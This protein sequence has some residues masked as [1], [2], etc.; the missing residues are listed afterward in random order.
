MVDI[1]TPRRTPGRLIAGALLA[2]L[3]G[4]TSQYMLALSPLLF[5]APVLTALTYAYAGAAAA[6]LSCAVQ[7]GV[8]YA[9]FGAALAALEFILLVAPLAFTLWTLRPGGPPL[10]EALRRTLPVWLLCAVLTVGLARYLVGMDL[11]DYLAALVR[12]ELEAL[13]AGMLDSF[14]TLFYGGDA[15]EALNLLTYS[16]GF[17]DP[18]ERARSV[19]SLTEALR[20]TLALSVPGTLLTSAALTGLLATA[21]PLRRLVREGALEALRW[22]PLN[23]W[24]LP[25]S[26]AVAATVFY[27]SSLLLF[28]FA[29]LSQAQSVAMALQMLAALA[30]RV[31][32]VGSLERRLRSMR[33]GARRLLI[34]LLLLLPLTANLSV[35][36]GMLSSLF[37]PTDGAVTRY[38]QKRRARHGGD[39]DTNDDVDGGGPWGGSDDDDGS[40]G[41]AD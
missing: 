33:P 32:A 12:R 30:F 17:L 3:I 24:R 19:A 14:L 38:L 37:S 18:A 40:D 39:D 13:P 4:L 9:S 2:V 23:K 10:F 8:A 34:A 6:L 7:L 41:D 26:M 36:Y 25:A 28:Q 27:V 15:P 1:K 11:A 31:Q 22:T 29:P 35:L 21:L 5:L 20:N 16:L